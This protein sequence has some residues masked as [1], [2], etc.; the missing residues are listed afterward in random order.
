MAIV[1]YWIATSAPD[2]ADP[3]RRVACTSLILI[4]GLRLTFNW[5]RGW[6]GLDHEDWRYRELQATTGRA[7]WVVSFIG[8]HFMP[9]LM[10]FLGC[11]PVFTAV[12]AG[13]APFGLLDGLAILVTGLAIALESASDQQLR[14]FVTRRRDRSEMLRSG[15]WAICRHPNYLGEILFWWGLF[16]FGLAADASSSWTVIGAVAISLLFRLVSLPMIERR[17]S[18]GKPAFTEHAKRSNMILPSF[19]SLRS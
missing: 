5:A 1:L 3:L 11:L 17:M 19:R 8:I 12:A 10:V 6:T 14:L 7:Y 16:L 9:T 15:L 18:E 2:V 4:W 13:S